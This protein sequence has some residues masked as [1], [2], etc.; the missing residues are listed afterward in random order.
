MWKGLKTVSAILG[1]AVIGLLAG[2]AAAQDLPVVKGRKIVASVNE[3]PITLAEFQREIAELTKERGPQGRAEKAEQIQLLNRMI[4]VRLIAQEA[5]RMGLDQIPEVK[6]MTDSFART[7]LREELTE[8]ITKGVKADEKAAERIYQ[9]MVREWKISAVLCEKEEEA[10]S[11]EAALKQEKNFGELAKRLVAEGKAKKAED[12]IYLKPK[13]VD[14]DLGAAVS[15]MAVGS[16]SSVIRMKPGFVIL[17]LEEIRIADD[18]AAKAQARQIALVNQGQAALKAY[19]E[20]LKKKYAK[21]HEDVLKSIDYEAPTPGFE[22]LLKDQRVVVEIKGDNPITVGDLTEEFRYE[23]FHGTERAAERKRMNAKKETILQALLHRRLFR[24]EALRLGLDKTESYRDKVK[25]HEAGILF[26]VFL[27]KVIAP[28]VKL[29][30]DE[31]KAYYTSHP[32][33]F[34]TPEMLRLRSL[35]FA[36][37]ADAERALESLRKGTEFK[38][39]ASNAEGQVA[40]TAQDILVFDG[41]LLVATELPEGVRKTVA[42]VKAGE[43]RIYAGPESRFYL[44]LVQEV[45]PAKQQAYEQAKAVI[46]DRLRREKPRKA[47][48]E[49]A[50]RL[51]LLSD[52][53]VYFK[54]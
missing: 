24:K 10:R 30:E 13:E 45:V 53:K 7:T 35:A 21:V 39:L 23:F 22:A 54:G 38:W 44:L 48:E 12:G 28:D 46:V 8:K 40:S 5:R 50:D 25:G 47:A 9:D 52:I 19:D 16:T 41:S 51:R 43:A 11:L 37:R 36:R 29:S 6:K 3:E 14:P 1:M 20:D 26:V 33:E 2:S 4:T 49:Y 42:G 17:R 34:T 18:P 15:A 31:M 27:G 32:K